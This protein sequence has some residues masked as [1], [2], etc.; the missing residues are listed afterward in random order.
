MSSVLLNM[1]GF[2]YNARIL[3]SVTLKNIANWRKI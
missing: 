3:E 2:K 1:T